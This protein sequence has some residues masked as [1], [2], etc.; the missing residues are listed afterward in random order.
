MLLMLDNAT[1]PDQ[2]RPLIPANPHSAVVVTSRNDLSGLKVHDDALIVELDVL[3]DEEATA[4]LT[5]VL[6]A[7]IPR[8]LRISSTNSPGLCARLPLALRDRGG[9][10]QPGPLQHGQ[11]L[12]RSSS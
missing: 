12:R 11:R 1:S 2:V 10:H 3:S 7:D 5:K 8:H 6:G 4:L 9:E